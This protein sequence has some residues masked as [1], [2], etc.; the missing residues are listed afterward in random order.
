MLA[1][2][3]S[4]RHGFNCTVLF[5]LEADGT[6]NPDNQKSLTGAE[7]LDFCRCGRDAAALPPVAG[8]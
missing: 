6:I 8:R 7:E 5:P 2:I 1:K 4:Q 3:L